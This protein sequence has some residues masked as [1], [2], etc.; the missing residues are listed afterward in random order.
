V[1]TSW[2]EGSAANFSKNA[3][4]AHDARYR[5]AGEYLDVVQGLWDSWEDDAHVADK[6][7]GLFVDPSKLH[8]LN[9]KGEFFS[10]K[11]PLN[12]RRS[13]QGQPV[14]FQA[15]ASEDGKNFAAKRADAIFVHQDDLEEAKAY[16]Q[17]LKSRAAGFGRDPDQ[18][19]ILPGA[20]PVVGSTEAEAERLYQELAGLVSIDNA[21]SMLGRPFNDYDFSVHDLDAP[22]PEGAA[23]FGANSN[24]S[25]VQKIMLA[26]KAH[27][28]SLRQ[29]ALRFATP[30]SQFVGTPDKV[31]D[32]MELWL[33][34]RGAD[35][36]NLFESL[37]GQLEVF[38]ETV[39]P[40]LQARGVYRRDYEGVTLRDHLGLDFPENR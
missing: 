8:A 1:V 31:A 25:A 40:I 22:F 21:L 10:V 7:S 5:L 33:N 9:H 20:R 16:Y 4:L 3:H 23:I 37:P 18:V 13:R 36:F 6:A 17:D 39:V 12:I 14:I 15:G 34:A 35:G 24:Q 19:S 28:L 38:V 29:V 30:R 32:Q 27:D 2:L 11:G 26:V